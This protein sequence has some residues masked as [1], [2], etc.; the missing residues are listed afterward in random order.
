NYGM[1]RQITISE[2]HPQ[3]PVNPYG[4]SKLFKEKMLIW[5]GKAGHLRWVV[6]RYFNAAGADPEG[7]L[8]EEHDPETH[9]IPSAIDAAL[10][11]REYLEI[12]G[13]DYATPDGTAGRDYVHVTDLA[14]AH[15]SALQYLASGQEN[16]ALNLGTEKGASVREVVAM[17]EKVSGCRVPSRDVS[18]RPG[19]PPTLVAKS[20]LARHILNWRPD[21]SNLETIVETAWRW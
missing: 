9:L 19:D 10:G 21:F 6:L 15:V 13:V 11:Q 18:R 14:A 17:V 7:E 20:E 8:G 4:E 3:T 2:N 5:M 12:C 1:P 16:L